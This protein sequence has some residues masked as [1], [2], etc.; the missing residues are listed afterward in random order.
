MNQEEAYLKDLASMEAWADTLANKS[1]QIDAN[2][3]TGQILIWSSSPSASAAQS[4]SR[5]LRRSPLR[6][7]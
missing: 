2:L 5:G 7:K 6:L 4:G 3:E 1:F